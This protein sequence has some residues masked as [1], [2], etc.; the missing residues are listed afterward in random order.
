MASPEWGQRC[1]YRRMDT[2]SFPSVVLRQNH[3]VETCTRDRVR[4]EHT[5][6]ENMLVV[7]TEQRRGELG[8][9]FP[10]EAG[11]SILIYLLP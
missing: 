9:D 7:C 4:G 6:G 5:T 8:K 2:M 11:P 10:R 3:T 1:A